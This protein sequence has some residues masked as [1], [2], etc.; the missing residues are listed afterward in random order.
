MN[1]KIFIDTNI[2]LRFYD[3]N[4]SEYKSLLK[5]IAELKEYIF[6]TKQ[7]EN[8]IERNKLEV[9]LNSFTTYSKKINFEKVCL[10][11]HLDKNG[12]LGFSQWN[13]TANKIKEDSK[14][15]QLK[16]GKIVGKLGKMVSEGTDDVSLELSSVY[17]KSIR[18]T[19][20]QL[21]EA[22]L[23]KELGNPPGKKNDTLGDQL[24]WEQLLDSLDQID[25]LWIISNDS[26]F[27]YERNS[28][29]FLNPFLHKEI[30]DKKNEIKLFMYKTLA[31]GLNSFNTN[32]IKVESLPEKSKLDKIEDYE[33][34]SNRIFYVSTGS[35]I[36][37]SIGM[38]QSCI[39]FNEM[40]I[41]LI[42][43]EKVCPDCGSKLFGP[44]MNSSFGMITEQYFCSKCKK[45]ID[46]MEE[47]K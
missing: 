43:S 8:E 27:M 29:H 37:S 12:T 42:I 46:T 23:R 14:K 45:Y 26:D 20:I 17:E 41:P 36:D 34:E 6:I 10:P 28:T 35:T 32:A 33:K 1:R 40:S 9:F 24:T 16:L 19:S 30:L 4:G 47:Y 13:K 2:Y 38:I 15:Q 22:R 39:G 18:Y 31:E 11:E 5:S 3:S 25:E 44:K 7:I 21:E